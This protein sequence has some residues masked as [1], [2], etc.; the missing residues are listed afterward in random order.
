MVADEAV[1]EGDCVEVC[2]EGVGDEEREGGSESET[3]SW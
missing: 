2:C 3:S 1:D